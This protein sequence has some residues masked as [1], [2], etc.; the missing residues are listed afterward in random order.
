GCLVVPNFS[1]GAVLMM[2]FAELAAPHFSE[3]EIIERHHHD[4][5]DAPSGTSIATA[6]RIASAGGISSDES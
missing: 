6:A 4:K 2:R 1:I 3:V 5:P